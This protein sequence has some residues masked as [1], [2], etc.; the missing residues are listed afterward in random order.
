MVRQ[1]SSDI[2]FRLFLTGAPKSGSEIPKLLPEED[3][4]IA[5]IQSDR[6]GRQLKAKAKLRLFHRISYARLAYQNLTG[7][8][9]SEYKAFLTWTHDNEEEFCPSSPDIR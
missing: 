7:K 9:A 2:E 3:K 6:G 4:I 5:V 1:P 8:N